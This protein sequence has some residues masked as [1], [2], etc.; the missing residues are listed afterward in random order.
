MSTAVNPKVLDL[1]TVALRKCKAATSLQGRKGMPVKM[2]SGQIAACSDDE[3]PWGLLAEDVEDA[4]TA[5]DAVDVYQLFPG[6]MLEIYV[7]S[8]GSAT[9]ITTANIGL[10]YDL[11]MIGSAPNEIG[12]LDL[13]A[14]SDKLFLVVDVA[15]EYEPERNAAA[16]SPGKAIVR[17][18]VVQTA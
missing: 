11:E 16:D 3:V 5:N 17:V 1:N 4:A 13:G 15:S 7:C 12:Y 6:S 14:T 10:A 9:A 18:Q 8:S 2:S